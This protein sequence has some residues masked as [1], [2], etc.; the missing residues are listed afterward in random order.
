MSSGLSSLPSSFLSKPHIFMHD[1][2]RVLRPPAIDYTLTLPDHVL[3]GIF[4]KLSA[5]ECFRGPCRVCRRWNSVISASGRIWKHV[6]LERVAYDNC[7]LLQRDG[8]ASRSVESL[9]ICNNQTAANWEYI[10]KRLEM[11]ECRWIKHLSKQQ[12]MEQILR[13]LNLAVNAKNLEC[14]NPDSSSV[15]TYISPFVCW[16]GETLNTLTIENP[17]SFD[18]TET[19][20][21]ILSSCKNL[22]ELFIYGSKFP[23]AP[24]AESND[25]FDKLGTLKLKRL[26]L[27]LYC[28]TVRPFINSLFAHCPLLEDIQLQGLAGPIYADDIQIFYRFPHL[29]SFTLNVN[30]PYIDIAHWR[31]NGDD[32]DDGK[33]P[34]NSLRLRL[35]DALKDNTVQTI[36][37]CCRDIET[38]DIV[39]DNHDPTILSLVPR[40]CRKLRHLV[41][42]EQIP[43]ASTIK[44]TVSLLTEKHPLLTTLERVTINNCHVEGSRL[45]SA[46]SPLLNLPSMTGFG[47]NK[48]MSITTA[49]IHALRSSSIENLYLTEMQ[50]DDGW[51]E[52]LE[53]WDKLTGLH[54]E[55]CTGV[56][57]DFIVALLSSRCCNLKHLY[58]KP[59]NFPWQCDENLGIQGTIS[60]KRR[61]ICN[62]LVSLPWMINLVT[63]FLPESV[64]FIQ[65]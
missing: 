14:Q 44:E 55:N 19:L 17:T 28:M 48:S 42:S 56:T 25:A 46:I 24:S 52:A 50:I 23:C 29:Q 57:Q 36:L 22:T 41:L 40:Y 35:R 16:L 34:W 51:I 54:L 4:E 1:N 9:V 7:P 21:I 15:R 59:S 13:L 53:A 61:I 64:Q 11:A 10:F 20:S 8:V 60:K 5:Q 33:R 26:K 37:S 63:T 49:Q 62:M 3:E 2:C 32:D 39:R 31:G 18:I 6:C 30:H 45:I 43:D 65:P 12:T 38:L 27:D 47:L 58:I